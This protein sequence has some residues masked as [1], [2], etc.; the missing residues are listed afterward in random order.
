LTRAVR[1]RLIPPVP[2][3]VALVTGA[4]R[5]LGR[6]VARALV[7]RG[8][9]VFAGVRAG[10]PPPG[11]EALPLDVTDGAQVSAA[12]RAIGERAGRL[13]L[14]VNNPAVLLDGDDA[15]LSVPPEL[16]SRTLAVNTVA[17]LRVA[18]ACW[19][20]LRR[21]AEQGADTILWLALDAPAELA[22]R[23]GH[24]RRIIPW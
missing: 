12:A 5:G 18:Q 16:L 15:I 11:T 20:L 7:A 6:E 4:S 8:V 17:P 21:G 14:L 24:D 2:T 13:D 19:P 22:G 1:R 3:P 10:A 9:R 23:F